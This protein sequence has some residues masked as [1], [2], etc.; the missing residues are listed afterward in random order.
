MSVLPDLPPPESLD[1]LLVLEPC[2]DPA[3]EDV[4]RVTIG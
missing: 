3:N 2:G 4:D 1:L